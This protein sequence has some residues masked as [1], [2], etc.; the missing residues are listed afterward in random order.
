[1]AYDL[2]NAAPFPAGIGDRVL[3]NDFTAAWHGRDEDVVAYREALRAEIQAAS[4][5]ANA[6]VAP[7]RAGNAVGLVHAIEPAGAIL[8]RIVLEA[9]RILRERPGQL[10][11]AD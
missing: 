7:A 10:L 11:L 3:R 4:D 6:R 8:Q 9:T 1:M 2:A 5:A